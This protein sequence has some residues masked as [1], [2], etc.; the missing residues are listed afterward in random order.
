METRNFT[1]R[2]DTRPHCDCVKRSRQKKK[3]QRP[4][5][6]ILELIAVPFNPQPN[7]G[8]A[9]EAKPNPYL[10]SQ[11]ISLYKR[12]TQ[13]HRNLHTHFS[14]LQLFLLCN[15]PI[16]IFFFRTYSEFQ[17]ACFRNLCPYVSEILPVNLIVKGME[18][19]SVGVLGDP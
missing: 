7:L 10:L 4:P 8:S 13:K 12:L 3:P 15:F 14:Q 9:V 5:K 17:L 18:F 6:E 11:I 2:G 16:F 19:H 1:E